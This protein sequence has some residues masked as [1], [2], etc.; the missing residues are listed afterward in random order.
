MGRL[1]KLRHGPRADLRSKKYPLGVPGLQGADK[2][3]VD[4]DNELTDFG[5]QMAGAAA[6]VGAASARECP[7]FLQALSLPER[8]GHV[9]YGHLV[10]LSVLLLRIPRSQEVQTKG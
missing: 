7:F 6:S 2:E 3:E 10:R 1:G 9:E 5:L 8:A 4:I